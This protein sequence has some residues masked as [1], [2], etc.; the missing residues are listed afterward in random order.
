MS[1]TYD[2][3][4]AQL[5]ERLKPQE[6]RTRAAKKP[7][8]QQNQTA[9]SKQWSIDQAMAWKD[10]NGP[11]PAVKIYARTNKARHQRCVDGGRYVIIGYQSY[12]GPVDLVTLSIHD[13]GLI[14][15]WKDNRYRL[16]SLPHP[17]ASALLCPIDNS[18]RE[19]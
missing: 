11:W 8:V 9:G 2:A 5:L 12:S 13:S 4:L 15:V 1:N 6:A 3:G 14:R 7:P 10:H 16:D 18:R 17:S 19:E